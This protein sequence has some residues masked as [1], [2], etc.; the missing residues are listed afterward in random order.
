MAA[1]KPLV[2][3]WCIDSWSELK[4]NKELI[5]KGWQKCCTSLFNIND[6]AKRNEALIAAASNQLEAAFI[7]N[8]EELP[9]QY[10]ESEGEESE[11]EDELDLTQAITFGE[12]KSTRAKKQIQR[13]GYFVDPTA[14]M[15][16]DE[17]ESEKKN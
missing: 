1:V 10:V 7:P 5:L 13:L 16:T 8:E 4:E 6:P 2:L 17:S 12:R 11:S 14:V 15:Q 3:Q 9:E